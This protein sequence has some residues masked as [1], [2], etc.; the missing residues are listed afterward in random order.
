M[1]PKFQDKAL[2]HYTYNV[3]WDA[4]AGGHLDKNTDGAGKWETIKEY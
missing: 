1:Q 2:G 3:F 4:K